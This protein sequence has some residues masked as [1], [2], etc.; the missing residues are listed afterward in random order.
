MHIA[1][2]NQTIVLGLAAIACVG[3]PG[4][5]NAQTRTWN[6]TTG[7]WQTGA[8]WVGGSAP[9]N[10]TSTNTALFSGTTGETAELNANTS[11]AGLLFS[12]AGTKT[13]RSDS[14]TTRT[15]T[16]GATGITGIAGS[17]AIAL[18]SVSNPLNLEIS[19]S[20]NW[21]NNSSSLLTV[22]GT[23]RP[24]NSSSGTDT[25][26][27][28]GAGNTTLSGAVN[29]NSSRVLGL[30]KAGVGS[31]T[32]NAATASTYTGTTAVAGGTLVLDFTNL[33]SSSNLV[34]AS[35]PLLFSGGGLSVKANGSGATSQSFNGTT[36]AGGGTLLVNPNGG[37]STTVSLGSLTGTAAGVSFLVGTASGG[38]NSKVTITT[39]TFADAQGIYGGRVVFSDG[40]AKGYDWATTSSGASPYTLSG[41]ASYA[42]L[43]TS[44]GTD[45]ANSQV[46]ASTALGGSRT[47]NTLKIADPTSS[48]SLAIGTGN[49][50]TLTSG[51][52]LATGANPF[53]ISGGTLTGGNGSGAYEV[54]IHQHNTGDLTISSAI[55]N[56]GANATSLTKAGNGRLVLTNA[57]TYTGRTAVNSGTLTFAPLST[58]SATGA[59]MTVS[60]GATVEFNIPTN[61]TFTYNSSGTASPATLAGAGTVLKTGSGTLV[62]TGTN[63]NAFTGM[64][65]LDSG[66]LS[67]RDA[68]LRGT[69]R[70][71]GD[72]SLTAGVNASNPHGFDS[73]TIDGGKTLTAAGVHLYNNTGGAGAVLAT[74]AGVRMTGTNTFAGGLTVRNP[75]SMQFWD[76]TGDALIGTGNVVFE[77]S[78][79]VIFNG[80]NTFASSSRTW[81]FNGLVNNFEVRQL[82][83]INSQVLGSGTIRFNSGN[84]SSFVLGN[85]ANTFSGRFEFNNI[86]TTLSVNSSGALGTAAVATSAAGAIGTLQITGTAGGTYGNAISITTATSANAFSLSVA[87]PAN[88]A[89]WS[90]LISGGSAPLSKSGAGT[91]ILSNTANSFSA[92]L[93]INDGTLGFADTRALGSG[94]S[95]ITLNA[96]GSTGRLSYTG[97]AS[98]TLARSITVASGTGTLS[99]AGSGTLTLSGTLASN[100]SVLRFGQGAFAVG[101]RITG[102]GGLAIDGG[103]VTLSNVTNNLSGTTTVSAGTLVVNGALGTG[104]L[105][106]A[107]GAI[108]MGSGTIGGNAT[109]AGIHSPGNSPGIE[110]FSSNLTY[111]GGASQVVWELFSNTSSN[112]PTVNYDQII[113]AGDLDFAGATSLGLSFGGT[114]FG[115]VDWDDAFWDSDQSWTLFDV[116]GTTTNFSNLVLTN[117]PS[118][119]LDFSGQAFANSSRAS[120][121]F[122]LAQ[123]GSD[124][125]IQYTVVVPEPAGMALAGIG[126]AAAAYRLRRRK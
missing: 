6:V 86:G 28:T 18:G 94:T 39:T 16:I 11:I 12:N 41:L 114:G 61:A 14:A 46:T 7:V 113:V 44:A 100:G 79:Q 118:A 34:S 25:L 73:I 68:S 96:S 29:N 49:T 70:V 58:V 55:A 60:P 4:V 106:V 63:T 120:N 115:A 50:L 95:L 26:T 87:D 22:L 8:N 1:T 27:I 88:T 111:S 69:L 107:S 48:Q 30:T 77:A 64:V 121:T 72:S 5:A 20:Q 52:L 23:V 122:T 32:M 76:S 92:G 97:V 17:G 71:I 102:I 42:S 57:N 31:L 19:A 9:S 123:Q 126:I 99:N 36:L 105:T 66:T 81:A 104:P 2:R 74:G 90:G 125:L 13:I 78:Q 101:G 3:L 10:S 21:T 112:S 103:M 35:S 117:D 38:D 84:I 40:S 75:T 83:T 59:G 116:A 98:G 37:T 47:T 108:L 45:M 67:G 119:W 24:S 110:S 43:D 85:A 33:A 109:I 124:V 51:G 93:R 89:T 56:N 62:L 80:V 54:V 15:L 82:T 65:L 91:L 53:S